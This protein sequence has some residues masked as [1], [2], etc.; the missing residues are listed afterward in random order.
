[1]YELI[2]IGGEFGVE[3]AKTINRT[4]LVLSIHSY[5]HKMTM[6]QV[7]VNCIKRC[8]TYSLFKS[9]VICRHTLA[10]LDKLLT[11]K[12]LIAVLLDLRQ[13]FEKSEPRYL[14]NQIYID[15]Y[16]LFLYGSEKMDRLEEIRKELAG[17]EVE[18]E[19]L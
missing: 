6:K 7:I 18:E 15:D 3:S 2:C 11:K 9:L 16:L 10:L 19:D 13:L 5:Y 4:S 8:L 17:V 14:L 1:V 12:Y